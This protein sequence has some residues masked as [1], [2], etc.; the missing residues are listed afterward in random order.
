MILDD[1]LLTLYRREDVSAPGEKPRYEPRKL[2]EGYYGELHYETSAER[3]TEKRGETRTDARVR[4]LQVR[5]VRE[6]D[7][8][9]L[10]PF[11][12]EQGGGLYEITRAYQGEDAE[13]GERITDLTLR[14]TEP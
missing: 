9:E 1:G 12:D 10:V 13:S 8:A 11:A 6:K 14:R 5:D 3:P 4:I 7:L 2:Y